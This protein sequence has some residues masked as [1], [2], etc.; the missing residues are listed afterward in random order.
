MTYMNRFNEIE[1]VPIQPFTL[2]ARR[3]VDDFL[4]EIHK[5]ISRSA[6]NEKRTREQTGDPERSLVVKIGYTSKIPFSAPCKLP[7]KEGYL[8][9]R[10]GDKEEIVTILGRDD[11]GIRYG[12]GKF[13]RSIE[14]RPGE[15]GVPTIE[16][17][18][19]TPKAALRGHQ[20]GF[21]PKNNTYFSWDIPT[22][23]DYI[24][25]L[26]W[27]GTNAIEILPPVTDDRPLTAPE[28]DL[29]FTTMVEL[30]T[31]LDEMDIDCWLWYPN[32]ALDYRKPEIR[33]IELD[34]RRRIFAALP[35]LDAVLVPGGDPGDLSP[36]VL[37]TW[38]TQLAEELHNHHPKAGIWVS[39]QTMHG[40]RAWLEEF[41]QELEREPSWLTGVC[42]GPWVPDC[43]E[44]LRRRVPARY[45]IRRYP[46]IGHSLACQ[47]PV[48][49]WDG[50]FA[51]TAGRESYNP[52]PR[53]LKML[54]NR[55]VTHAIGS[56]TYS[57]GIN[58][59]VNKFVWAAQDWDPDT[60]VID[61]LRDY[62]RLF[63]S[64]E[65]VDEQVRGLIAFEE[66]WKLPLG[67]NPVISQNYRRWKHLGESFF[68]EKGKE[69]NFRI[70]LPLTRAY[71][72]EYQKRRYRVERF[73]EEKLSLLLERWLEDA[74]RF[75]LQEAQR[76]DAIDYSFPDLSELKERC[77]DLA[78]RAFRSIG[79]KTSVARHG[80]QAIV[81]GAF[82][83]AMEESISDL[84]WYRK[85]LVDLQ[86]GLEEAQKREELAHL[87]EEGL[88]RAKPYRK[89]GGR[90]VDFRK[91][92]QNGLI[93]EHPFHSF[94]DYQ[95]W[96]GREARKKRTAMLPLLPE[97]ERSFLTTSGGGMIE[98][99]IDGLQPDNAYCL[100][101]CYVSYP[102]TSTIQLF[103]G[104][105]PLGEPLITKTIST[106]TRQEI[107][108]D[109]IGSEGDLFLEWNMEPENLSSCGVAWLL[110]EG[111]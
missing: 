83:D 93:I 66:S 34:E 54:H 64:P 59:D 42:G 71:Y 29:A 44:T 14:L 22:Y 53:A 3:A 58:D 50:A 102:G 80:G 17:I 75:H 39:A 1:I 23:R 5:R 84:P 52:R 15:I 70:L 48:P 110:L 74:S 67:E 26:C 4:L 104:D 88:F 94:P 38:L 72:D 33:S 25:E 40:G 73:R 37:F 27:F 95:H 111:R 98:Y 62:C 85:L 10:S 86:K 56:I 46:D 45:P 87:L 91:S 69:E 57:E 11:R 13:L 99:L 106:I 60:Q 8:I 82:L 76:V 61:T 100:T 78:D 7:G 89:S 101:L 81:R 63:I 41:Y 18:S 36:K 77:I 31:L 96:E 43:Y 19:S 97:L 90:F 103:A 51:V 20:L 9:Q 49:D 68:Q 12:L 2:Q 16:C 24:R 30:S 65:M 28:E 107:P 55:D 92:P 47:F 105:R 108:A 79:W 21:R 6:G 32:K 35:R 109:L